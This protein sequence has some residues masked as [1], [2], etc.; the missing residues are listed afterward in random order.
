M[1]L[2]Y[3]HANDCK[4]QEDEV[5]LKKHAEEIGVAEEDAKRKLT[6]EQTRVDRLQESLD[7]LRA[8]VSND[9]DNGWACATKIL[10]GEG[11]EKIATAVCLEYTSDGFHVTIGEHKENIKD[12]EKLKLSLSD[13]QKN[14]DAIQEKSRAID[15]DLEKLGVDMN[16][17]KESVSS[18]SLIVR[19]I[20]KK[21]PKLDPDP[22]KAQAAQIA[23][24]GK[25]EG[26]MSEKSTILMQIIELMDRWIEECKTETDLKVSVNDEERRLHA[27]DSHMK[28]LVAT[29]P[30]ITQE[31]SKFGK[32]NS[33][34][35][36]LK[37]DPETALEHATTLERE[38]KL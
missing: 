33:L 16:K 3:E 12:M 27:I 4:G 6:E 37:D 18:L 14:C 10:K 2:N 29:D 38:R 9:L 30:W 35:D 22:H 23:A 20:K 17:W 11:P 1:Q 32:R 31:Q 28:S 19:D 26:F 36:F 13:L 7:V 5:R 21:F 25:L 34:Y 8:A 15:R 24:R